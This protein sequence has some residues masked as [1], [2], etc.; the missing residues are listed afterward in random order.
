MVLC[1]QRARG[2]ETSE[3]HDGG[4]EGSKVD[5]R[6]IF[7]GVLGLLSNRDRRSV[8]CDAT[9]DA[10]SYCIESADR[11]QTKFRQDRLLG[12]IMNDSD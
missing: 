4:A 2:S 10:V 3:N 5:H 6:V 9:S 1:V 7:L 8:A 12:E 11:E